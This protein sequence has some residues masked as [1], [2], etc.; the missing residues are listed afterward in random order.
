VNFALNLQFS[1]TP[2]R[3][4]PKPDRLPAA[5]RGTSTSK[6]IDGH[7]VYE[8]PS[9]PRTGSQRCLFAVC[10]IY[11]TSGAFTFALTTNDGRAN[12]PQYLEGVL[13]SIRPA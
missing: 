8:S 9:P 5:V 7:F 12:W 2:T 13:R 4:L 10:G 3:F 1:R 6:R 11:W